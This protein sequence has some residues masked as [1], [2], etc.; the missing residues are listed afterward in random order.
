MPDYEKYFAVR[1]RVTE[2]Q[3][4]KFEEAKKIGITHKMIMQEFCKQS[5]DVQITVFDK[6]KKKSITLPKGFLCKKNKTNE[7]S[8]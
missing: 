6:K 3:F 4:S 7:Q 8:D 5:E 1:F 2:F